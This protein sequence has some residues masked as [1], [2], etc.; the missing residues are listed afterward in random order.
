SQHP[1]PFDKWSAIAVTSG[2]IVDITDPTTPGQPKVY[3]ASAKEDAGSVTVENGAYTLMWDPSEDPESKIVCYELYEK[4]GTSP[5]WTKIATLEADTTRYVINKGDKFSSYQYRVR[6]QDGA[7]RYSLYSDDSKNVITGASVSAIAN[8]T[9]YPNPFNSN[10]G[11]TN[12]AF[13]LSGT[14]DVKI[15]IYDMMGYL[16]RSDLYPGMTPGSHAIPWDGTNGAGQ[17][18][19]KGAYIVRITVKA[20]GG[21][22]TMIRKVGV[23]H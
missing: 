17:K 19:A 12:I 16:V 6:S 3:S 13:T 20:N 1:A 5:V 18:V 11:K 21:D 2:T 23:I 7:G 15:D 4:A 22:I 10:T 9:N 8:I 14:Y